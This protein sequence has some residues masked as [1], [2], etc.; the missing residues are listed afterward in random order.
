[1]TM[2]N[3]NTIA[4]DALVRDFPVAQA[5]FGI[6]VPQD[7]NVK[8]FL[9]FA[10]DNVF[11][12]Y[13]P[14]K[15]ED[16][17]FE[18][19]V[20]QSVLMWFNYPLNQSLWISGPTGCGKSSI[21][22]QVAN[23]LNWPLMKVTAFP[24]MDISSQIGGLRIVT[25]SKTGDTQTVYVHGPLAM[26][27][28]YGMIYL[29]DEYD[30]LENSCANA[31]NTVLEGGNLIIAETNEVIKKHP[32]FRFVVTANSIGQGD[33]TGMYGGVKMQNTANLDRYMFISTYYMK[34]EY[35]VKLVT[36][37]IPDPTIA[38][39]FV[40]VANNIRKQFVGN[41]ENNGNEFGNTLS[42]TCSTRS[43]IA[44]VTRFAIMR[45]SRMP[46]SLIAAFDFHIGNRAPIDEKNALHAIIKT[47]FG[48]LADE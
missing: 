22:E 38:L 43:L 26:A 30:Q 32:N 5:S 6:K 28:K 1:M 15:N 45:K 14:L 42:V 40:N 48:S 34:E 18:P 17:I 20:R 10:P 24:E 25:D 27:Y 41:M 39:R 36:N 13:V 4:V 19:T 35:E 44:W 9:G 2:N 7:Q 3:V 12:D 29:L 16:Y 8:P 37:S 23:R 46:N 21:V 11:Q 31:F 47:Q 33:T